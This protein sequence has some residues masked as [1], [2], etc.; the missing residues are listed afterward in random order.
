MAKEAASL[1]GKTEENFD[2]V[3]HL[4]AGLRSI[5]YYGKSE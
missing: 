5:T 1:L 4:L 2:Y 3:E